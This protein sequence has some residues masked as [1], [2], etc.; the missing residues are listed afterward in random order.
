M[1]KVLKEADP[2]DRND[3]YMRMGLHLAYDPLERVV[4]GEAR[5]NMYQ[6]RP[7]DAAIRI[8]GTERAQHAIGTGEG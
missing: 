1:A 7:H 2:A 5:P 3:L 8:P 6:S 4:A